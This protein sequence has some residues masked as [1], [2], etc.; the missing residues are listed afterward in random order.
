MGYYFAQ[1]KSNISYS[2]VQQLTSCRRFL[3]FGAQNENDDENV[4]WQPMTENV[5]ATMSCVLLPTIALLEQLFV[6][7]MVDAVSIF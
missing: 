3:L 2:E 6:E 5:V 1:Q 4:A 7:T